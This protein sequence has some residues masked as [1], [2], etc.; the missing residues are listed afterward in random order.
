M[1]HPSA[2]EEDRFN[3]EIP[4]RP[5]EYLL[6]ELKFDA[7]RS[8]QYKYVCS[9]CHSKTSVASVLEETPK[10]GNSSCGATSK[11]TSLAKSLEVEVLCTGLYLMHLDRRFRDIQDVFAVNET[12]ITKAILEYDGI[13]ALVDDDK[14]TISFPI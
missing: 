2:I 3:I 6:E 1:I 4:R 10:C 8:F 7:V 14:Q 12:Q 11:I 5:T 13:E 9:F